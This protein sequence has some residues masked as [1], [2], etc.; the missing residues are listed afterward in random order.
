MITA[1]LKQVGAEM[2]L[3]HRAVP[4]PVASRL[5]S[6]RAGP[7]C[8]IWVPRPTEVGPP[9]AWRRAFPL[10]WGSRASAPPGNQTALVRPRY[11]HRCTRG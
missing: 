3:A 2:E 11:W 7:N 8:L 9:E 6:A 1:T 10:C 4:A 5:I